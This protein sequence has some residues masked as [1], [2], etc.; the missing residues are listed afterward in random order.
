MFPLVVI[1]P[2]LVFVDEAPVECIPKPAYPL[3]V[4]VPLLVFADVAP[5]DL[6]P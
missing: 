2:L 5:V 4:I 6:I 1:E 3:V